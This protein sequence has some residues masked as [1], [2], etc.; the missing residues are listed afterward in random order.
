MI[1][2]DSNIPMY[3]V[4][5]DHPW[6]LPAQRALE[7]AATRHERLVTD[8]EVYQEILHRYTAIDR[9]DAIP[10]AFDLLDR[11][12]D[13]VFPIEEPDVRRAKDLLLAT[14]A[15][16]ARDALHAAVME[17]HEVHR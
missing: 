2:V 6:K 7:R 5:R 1:F 9:R 4:G 8:A 15:I 14:R 11:V 16:S 13:E 3:I 12:V 10:P 17:H